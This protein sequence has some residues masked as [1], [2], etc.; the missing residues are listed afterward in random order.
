MKFLRGPIEGTVKS[1]NEELPE[2]VLRAKN[3]KPILLHRGS[4]LSSSLTKEERYK[5][6]HLGYSTEAP[7]AGEAFFFT[8]RR[9]SAN[10]Y[11]RGKNPNKEQ[12]I[13]KG[14]DPHIDK[15]YLIMRNPYVHDFKGKLHR[16]EENTY[17]KLIRSAKEK[18]HDGVIFKN[19]FDGGEYT[20]IDVVLDGKFVGETI[21]G[22][23]S[24]EQILVQETKSLVSSKEK[25]RIL[26]AE[27]K[28][29]EARRK[30]R[31]KKREREKE[32]AHKWQT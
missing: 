15:V 5:P 3:G 28:R 30:G 6:E 17:F 25:R 29:L 19:T 4:S 2:G 24:P 14:G 20:Y 8:S 12:A 1:Y 16:D 23:F 7:S 21:Y 22:V 11:S 10:Y 13:I 26:E 18:G 27:R 9:R 31:M 32:R